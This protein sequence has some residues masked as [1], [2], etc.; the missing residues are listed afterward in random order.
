MGDAGSSTRQSK[1]PLA[2]HLRFVPGGVDYSGG[3]CYYQLHNNFRELAKE[4]RKAD[5]VLYQHSKV[6]YLPSLSVLAHAALEKLTAVP[7]A[8]EWLNALVL[9]YSDSEHTSVKS[10]LQSYPKPATKGPC[11]YVFQRGDIAWNCRTCQ[12]DATCVI[13]D[14]CF[15]KSEHEGHEVYFHRTS[16]GGCCDCGDAEAW[17]AAGC[18]PDHRPTQA[19]SSDIFEAVTQGTRG[20]AAGAEAVSQLPPRVAAALGVVIGAAVHTIEQAVQ[21]SGIGADPVQWKRVWAD[22]AAKICNTAPHLEEYGEEQVSPSDFWQDEPQKFPRDFKLQL[23]LHNDDVHTFEE[24]IE[25]LNGRRVLHEDAHQLVPHRESAT[26][27]THL[28]DSEGQVTVREYL[29]LKTALQGFQRLKSVGLHCSVVSTPQIQLEQRAQELVSWLVEISTA[30]SAATALI[31]QAF[32]QVD[33]D[34]S[35]G[36]VAVWKEERFIPAFCGSEC[37]SD[38]E[39]TRIRLEVFPPQ[40]PSSYLTREE[41]ELLHGMA[42]DMNQNGFCSWVHTS[43][44][45]YSRVAYRLPSQRY[46]KSPHSLW[47]TLP[48]TYSDPLPATSRHPILHLLAGNEPNSRLPNAL[49]DPIFLVDTD[50]RKQQNPKN[51]TCSLYPHKLPG[52]NLVSGVGTI[53]LSEVSKQRPAFPSPMHVRHLLAISSFKV[54]TS[55][56]LIILL[57]DPYPTKQLRGSLHKLFLSLL[58]DS[59]FKSRFAGALGVAYRPLSTLFCAGVGTDA[60]TPLHFSVQILT[61]G[62]LVRALCS[63]EV[64]K[65]LV[66]SDQIDTIDSTNNISIGVFVPPIAHV[67]VR[68]VHT[69]LLG[70]TKEVEMI[71]KNTATVSDDHSYDGGSQKSDNFLQALTYV[72]GEHPLSTSLPAAPDDAFLDSRSTRH[73]R[74]PHLLRDLEYVLETP[75]TACRL[76]QPVA[77]D[78]THN[79]ATAFA[80]ML[81]LAQGMDAQKRK[82][83]GGHVEYEKNRWLE[84]FGL[85]LNMAGVRDALAES[86][87]GNRTTD[88]EES[89]TT[90][91]DAIGHLLGSLLREIKYWLYRESLLEPGL[92]V[93]N[94]NNGLEISALQRST[95]H[96]S[97]GFNAAYSEGSLES[98]SSTQ[99][100]ALACATGIRMTEAQLALIENAL[101]IEATKE[102]NYTKNQVPEG[103]SRGPLAA[104]WLRVPHSPIG[105]DLLSFHLPL[106]RAVAKC[107]SSVCSSVVTEEQRASN[108]RSWWKLPALDGNYMSQEASESSLLLRHPLIPLLKSTLRSSNCRINWSDGPDCTPTEA[109]NRR[110]RSRTVSANVAIAKVV[111]SLADHPMRCIVTAQQVERHIWAR[112]GA[113]VAGMAMNYSSVPLCRSFRDLDLLLI[114]FSA[115]GMSSG[116]GAARI[117]TLM[118]SRF[119]MEG[120]LCDIERKPPLSYAV[121]ET[122]VLWENPPRLQDPDHAVMLA[123]SFFSTLCVLVTELPPP[124]PTSSRDDTP[125]RQSIRRELLHALITEP[126]SYSEAMTAAS[127]GLSR[128]ED[129]DSAASSGCSGSIFTNAFNSVLTDIGNQRNKRGT[130]GSSGPPQYELKAECCEEY[131]PSFFHLKRQ[132]HQ[133]AMDVVARLRKTNQSSDAS[134]LPIVCPPPKAHPRFLSCR[135]LL[136]LEATDAAIRRVLLFALTN[137]SWLPPPNP[138]TALEKQDSETGQ[139][140][141]ALDAMS[142]SSD[143]NDVPV[144]TFN[145]RLLRSHGSTITFAGNQDMQM[146]FSKE[147]VASS[148]VSYLEV[149]QL[150]T[151]QVHTLEECAALHRVLP[152]LDAESRQISSSLSINSYLRRLLM[153]PTNLAE[154]WALRPYPDGPLQSAGSGEKRGSILGYLIALYEHRSVKSVEESENDV[155]DEGHGGA[156]VLVSQGLKFILRFVNALVNNASNVS[157]AVKSAST[158][159]PARQRPASSSDTATLWTIDETTRD[160]I[161]RMLSGL[162]D[163]WPS[164]RDKSISPQKTSMKNSEA[165]KAAQRRQMEIMKKMQAQFAATI[166]PSDDPAQKRMGQENSDQCIICRCD[167]LEGEN[168]GPLGYLGHVQ[169]SRVSQLR[170]ALH[171]V[172]NNEK[173]M[174]QVIGHMGCQVRT[175]LTKLIM[176]IDTFHRFA[177]RKLWTRHRLGVCLEAA[178]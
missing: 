105:G 50:L 40:L 48:S 126:R 159:V 61:A 4:A 115:S 104:D 59:R 53:K 138:K 129:N 96:V 118:L 68:C 86:P 82:I 72:A 136:H 84:A 148:A 112:N 10:L 6:H 98:C 73:K 91:Y 23:R 5:D 172:T 94:N 75:G 39:R 140:G 119:G 11:G 164:S 8:V 144:T 15:Q 125:L 175:P 30:H 71:L 49:C 128:R 42:M 21:G 7:N 122:D 114:Q 2:A 17:K 69:N 27:M 47:G 32:V 87:L 157:E 107:V 62:S 85:S 120:Y 113:S 93:A 116:L 38:K 168:N 63:P 74:L 92:P 57:L 37:L 163:L 101:K 28:V 51:V 147:V 127:N 153:V 76:L 31:V 111:H 121:D 18:C 45:F 58:T 103:S 145:R 166:K 106:H 146:P 142:T 9:E 33:R 79:F 83:S 60:D 178:L 41:A 165:G 70:S 13:C 170:C 80:R 117:F 139:S 89:G 99:M 95:L 158:G 25:A 171:A 3:G 26:K 131:D 54:P 64:G 162:P 137:G 109:Q 20:Q 155:G 19:S 56:I 100:V 34:H 124:P 161:V 130:R 173:N 176:E 43:P 110:S 151:L 77:N 55:P 141:D 150:L 156:R 52:L 90:V 22:E 169:R 81:R 46:Q 102:Q 29:S 67:I 160:T 88:E 167:H 66:C 143:P 174:Y 14:S 154:V 65:E 1:F 149:L 177:K 135:L 44:H 24:V 152:D 97:N 133:H 108:P 134:C 132:D 12:T 78:D 16:P 36:G 123:E 35:I